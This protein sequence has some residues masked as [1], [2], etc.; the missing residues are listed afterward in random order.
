[1]TKQAPVPGRNWQCTVR[2][3]DGKQYTVI[4]RTQKEAK[5]M[6]DRY[7]RDWLIYRLQKVEYG[8]MK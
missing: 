5:K 6:Y 1:M 4:N 8:V 7:M 3:S 2:F